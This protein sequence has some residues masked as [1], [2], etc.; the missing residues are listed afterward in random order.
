MHLLSLHLISHAAVCP[1][2]LHATQQ[3]LL[4]A[5]NCD[6]QPNIN[7]VLL[8]HL[9]S[10]VSVRPA[11]LHATQQQL[12]AVL[13]QN[14]RELTA[15]LEAGIRVI[16]Q[17]SGCSPHLDKTS[18]KLLDVA[19][20]TAARICRE[21]GWPHDTAAAGP[22]FSLQVSLIKAA[23][24]LC[25]SRDSSSSSSRH[26]GPQVLMIC[27]TVCYSAVKLIAPLTGALPLLLLA[28]LVSLSG[29][30]A[31]AVC[32]SEAWA[33]QQAFR[34]S[35][36]S[37][38]RDTACMV[39]T[40]EEMIGEMALQLPGEAAAAAAAAQQLQQQA[41]D[42]RKHMR[43]LLRGNCPYCGP[44]GRLGQC[45]S[46]D[47]SIDPTA[48]VDAMAA[49]IASAVSGCSRPSSLQQELRTAFGTSGLLQQLQQFGE[50]VCHQLPVS[51]WCCNPRCTNL[52]QQSEL[53]LR[54]SAAGSAWSSAG[55]SSCTRACVSASLPHTSCSCSSRSSSSRI[56]RVCRHQR[57]SSST[58]S[59]T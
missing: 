2:E 36:F 37:I 12:P 55:R 48:E 50:A 51:L 18:I 17:Q 4:P 58:C 13:K 53:E 23:E 11:E 31:G 7:H 40:V 26:L 43:E 52:Q 34:G 54:A 3:Q 9:S 14:A 59:S 42:V 21:L 24:V 5:V 27:N 39:A 30:I 44:H 57:L 46:S 33:D 32:S 25:S 35:G 28:R 10:H 19:C 16:Y 45:C 29:R 49:V 38:L 41:A 6:L 1:A 47:G 22:M 8:C 15:I 56:K 20:T